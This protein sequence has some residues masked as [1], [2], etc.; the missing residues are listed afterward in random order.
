MLLFIP[1]LRRSLMQILMECVYGMEMSKIAKESRE[2]RWIELQN[3]FVLIL[4]ILPYLIVNSYK[5]IDF[6]ENKKL[7]NRSIVLKINYSERAK[8]SGF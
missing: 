2:G 1:P 7:G 5:Y 6:G 8:I 4:R 3:L